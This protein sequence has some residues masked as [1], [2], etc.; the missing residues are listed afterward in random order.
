MALWRSGFRSSSD[1]EFQV[2]GAATVHGD[3][4]Y[5][6][7]SCCNIRFHKTAFVAWPSWIDAC[8]L[9]V[10]I[11]L[12]FVLLVSEEL[13]ISSYTNIGE[14]GTQKNLLSAYL[15]TLTPPTTVELVL[16]SGDCL[17]LRSFH[18]TVTVTCCYTFH[19]KIPVLHPF[20]RFSRTRAF[21]SGFQDL[22]ILSFKIQG[23]S[24]SFQGL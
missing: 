3:E 4:L 13:D 20:S 5:Q 19:D 8:Q 24:R 16:S 1:S 2:A 22:E 15:S 10:N 17:S 12:E 9:V 6:F 18:W 14:N 23:L 7:A 11:V 21:S